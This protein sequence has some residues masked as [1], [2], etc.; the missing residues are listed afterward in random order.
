M[1]FPLF[2]LAMAHR[3][4]ARQHACANII[5][6][7]ADHQPAVLHP[8]RARRGERA[9]RRR[10]GRGRARLGGDSARCRSC[11]ASCCPT[12]C[13]PMAVQASL[14]LGWAILNA[15]GLSFIGLGV[16]PPTPEW[17]I[18]VSEGAQLHHHRRVVAGRV[19]GPGADA[20]GALLQP[21]G[22]R[23]ARHARSAAGAHDGAAARRSSDLPVALLAPVTATVQALRRR[24]HS[25]W[26]RGEIVWASWAKAAR[27]SRSRALRRHAACSTR[28]ARDHRRPHRASSGSDLLTRAGHADLRR[29][30][31]PR[32]W[33]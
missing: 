15:A 32:A 18:M 7:T 24:R 27:A 31:R 11:C 3:R 25:R 17:G 1:A 26:Q 9:A 29:A 16:R 10:L 22:R 33:R 14:N 30:A 20:R 6:A 13:R 12:S 8:L 23:T 4:G 2:V 21:A 5:I 28:P 19:P